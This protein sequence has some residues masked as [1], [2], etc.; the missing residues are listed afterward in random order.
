VPRRIRMVTLTIAATATI[1]TTCVT[2]R[3]RLAR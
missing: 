1:E 2:N 3:P